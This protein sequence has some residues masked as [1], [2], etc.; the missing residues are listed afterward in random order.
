MSGP[1]L[2]SKRI[3]AVVSVVVV[4]GLV[5]AL[6]LFVWRGF[7]NDIRTPEGFKTYIDSFGWKGYLVAMGI[8]ML[9]V[10]VALIPGEVVEIGAGCAFGWLGG[11]LIC[12]AGVAL[13]SSAVF[14]LTKRIGIKMVELFVDPEK[15][16]NLRFLNSEKK[17]KRTVFLLFFIPG[18]P[19]DLITYFIGL[20]RIR[21]GEFLA[22]S[23]IA[24]IPSVLSSALVGHYV[25]EENYLTSILIFAATAL[26]S[27]VGILLY[28]RIISRKQKA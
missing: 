18:T 22:I 17:L 11:T 10:V 28:N 25:I 26:I 8:Q 6:A 16:N 15:I 20:T 2:R 21:L 12:L 3:L 14:L 27:L 24:R 5:S 9:Q 1:S 4:V 23:I 19:K 13:A 7:E